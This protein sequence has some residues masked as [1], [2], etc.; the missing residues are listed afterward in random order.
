[1][2][3]WPFLRNLPDLLEALSGRHRN[4]PSRFNLVVPLN[5]TRSGKHILMVL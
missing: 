2:H 4:T 1:M 5:E 3:I